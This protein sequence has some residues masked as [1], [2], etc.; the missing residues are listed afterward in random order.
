MDKN[1]TRNQVESSPAL[2][3]STASYDENYILSMG[4]ILNIYGNCSKEE[5]QKAIRE[6]S[7]SITLIQFARKFDVSLNLLEMLNEYI[8][9]VFPNCRLSEVFNGYGAFDNL[10]H[11]EHLNKI[12][13]LCIQ[14]SGDLDLTPINRYCAL[15]NLAIGGGRIAEI[16]KHE[17]I[18]NLFLFDRIKDIHRIGEMKNLRTLTLSRMTLKNLDFLI[19]LPVLNKLSFMA[20]GTKNLEALPEIGEIETLLFES[21]RGLKIEHLDVINNMRFLKKISF[22]TQNNL[23]DL[24]WLTKE[25]NVDVTNCKNYKE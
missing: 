5:I 15:K 18:E 10:E 19:G 22:D 7:N 6:K 4:G 12:T 13:D 16:T 20:G 14:L 9:D 21:V 3:N 1:S 8:L 2:K 11:L 25:I 24:N 17:S 23:T